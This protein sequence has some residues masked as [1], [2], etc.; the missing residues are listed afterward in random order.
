MES[1]IEFKAICKSKN[2]QF[3][4][5]SFPDKFSID[6]PFYTGLII[7]CIHYCMG[8]VSISKDGEL[9]KT[10]GEI[11]QGVYDAG[12]VTGDVHGGNRLGG[13]SLMECVILDRRVAK[14]ALN[15]FL[16]LKL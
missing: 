16:K 3:G 10:D 9:I 6:G 12:E 7:P 15:Y 2:D 4:R 1:L 8:G 13:N 14:A 11:M 5:T